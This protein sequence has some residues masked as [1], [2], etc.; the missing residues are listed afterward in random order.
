MLFPTGLFLFVFLPITVGMFFLLAKIWGARS[1]STWLVLSSLCFYACW[2]PIHVLLLVASVGFNYCGG[3]LILR[4][5]R[6]DTKIRARTLLIFFVTANLFVLAYFK[7]F[8][9]FMDSVN[10]AGFHAPRLAIALPLGISFF[11]F[12]QIAYLVDVYSDKAFERSPLRYALFVTYFPHL[13]AG[14]ILHHAQIMPQFKDPKIYVPQLRSF[15]LGLSFLL[16]GLAKKVLIADSFAPIADQSFSDA[17]R[18]LLAAAE[19]WSGVLSYTLQ[20]YF[21][22]S[23]YSDMAVGLSLLIGIRLPYNFNSPYK[24]LNIIE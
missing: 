18:G 7:Y 14:P 19:A 15:A 23:G 10:A 2:R 22:F 9:F 12:T 13:V 17:A 4:A 3:G 21:D 11:T 1:A 20:I 24:A 16:F 6:D 8:N 5:K